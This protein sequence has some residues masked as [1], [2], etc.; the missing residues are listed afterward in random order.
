VVALQWIV[1]QVIHRQ[2]SGIHLR[3]WAIKFTKS[4]IL[5]VFLLKYVEEATKTRFFND[6]GE[7]NGRLVARETVT[8]REATAVITKVVKTCDF[9]I[10][11]IPDSWAM[12]C[13]SLIHWSM[14]FCL[15]VAQ[16][17]SELALPDFQFPNKN[18]VLCLT[19]LFLQ[20]DFPYF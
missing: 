2:C 17:N 13:V 3:G 8:S 7:T 19:F 14:Q 11:S 5:G 12:K 10:R 16:I 9:N 6:F 15:K 18:D 20:G 1:Y 4:K